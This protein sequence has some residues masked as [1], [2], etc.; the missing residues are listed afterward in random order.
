MDEYLLCRTA[1]SVQSRSLEQ[2]VSSVITH[3][4]RPT[5][6]T[7]FTVIQHPK[8]TRH[9]PAPGP[10]ASR[11][12]TAYDAQQE[13]FTLLDKLSYLSFLIETYIRQNNHIEIQGGFKWLLGRVDEL[14][15]RLAT[16]RVKFEDY[17]WDYTG[18]LVLEELMRCVD[19]KY[20]ELKAMRRKRAGF[21]STFV[22]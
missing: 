16:L 21:G 11:N 15:S 2:S 17:K 14:R 12:M 1:A 22:F 13:Q 4:T 6:T 19:K 10:P 9:L 3:I 20:A 18:L 7:L 8:M 5:A